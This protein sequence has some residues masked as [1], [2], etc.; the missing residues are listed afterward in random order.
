MNRTPFNPTAAAIAAGWIGLVSLPAAEVTITGADLLANPP[1]PTNTW[2]SA[3]GKLTFTA[4]NDLGKTSTGA[5]G[6]NNP[7][8]GVA[9]G[10]NNVAVDDNASGSEALELTFAADAG[11]SSIT[12]NFNTADGVTYISGFTSNPGVVFVPNPNTTTAIETGGATYDDSTGTVTINFNLNISANISEIKF[13]RPA[14][15]AGQTLTISRPD[16][17]ANRQTA[18]RSYTYETDIDTSLQIVGS[19]AFLPTTTVDNYE[20]PD[21]KLFIEGWADQTQTTAANFGVGGGYFFGI[22][23]GGNDNA[24]NG[25]ESVTI[26]VASDAALD[27]MSFAWPSAVGTVEIT[28]FASDPLATFDGNTV[29]GETGSVAYSAGTLTITLTR[30]NGQ[31]RLVSFGNPSASIG[32]LLT[33]QRTGGTG[34]FSLNYIGYLDSIPPS[35]PVI[36]GDLTD[37]LSVIADTPVDLGVILDP[38]TSPAPTYLWEYDDGLGGGF[39]P[40]PGDNTAPIYEFTGGTAT[41][42]NY[43]VTVTN[44]E[45]S[46]TST[47]TV[48]STDDGDG[49]NNQWEIDNFGD[50]LLYEDDDVEPDGLTNSVEF[51]LGTDPN[52]VDT[53]GDGLN[54]ADEGPNNADPLVLDTD[55]D[56]Y[57]DG[58]EVNVAVPATLPDDPNSS[59]GVSDGRNSIGITFNTIN[60]PGANRTLG[61]NAL[62]GAPGYVQKNWNSTGALLGSAT[63]TNTFDI[64]TPSTGT[65]VDSSGNSTFTGFDIGMAGTFSV[66]NNPQQPYGSLYSAYLFANGTTTKVTMDITDIP[67]AR[68]DVVI[69]PLG[70]NGNQRGELNQFGETK[71]YAARPPA[72]VANGVDPVWYLSSDQTTSSNGTFENFPRA[73]HLV[74]RGLTDPDVGFDLTRTLD[75]IGIAAIQIVEDLDSDG[76][77]M[78]DNYE[79]SVGLDPND[80]GTTDPVK[81]GAN[82]DF[83]G[84][85]LL[86]IDEHDNGTNPTSNDT[87]NDG[88]T[89]DVET[90]TGTWVSI[91]DTGTDP[92]IADFDNDGVPDGA[93]TNTGIFVNASDTGGNPLVANVDTDQD[94]W[95]DSYEN[96]AGATDFLN[97]E[98][99]GG[100]N[101]DGFAIAFDAANGTSA[102]AASTVFLP[103]TYAGAPGVEM[104]NWNRSGA[105]GFGANTGSITDFGGSLS[106]SA[107]AVVGDGVTGVD[108]DFTAGGGA[109]SSNPELNSPYGRLF[110]SFIFGRN[111]AGAGESPDSTVTLTGIPYTTYDVYV[112]V[113]S[114]S[115]G[116]IGTISSTAAGTTYSFTTGVVNTDPGTYTQTTD[117]GA[118]NPIANYA[119]FSAQSG[120]TFDVTVTVGAAQNSLG[121]YGIQVVDTTGSQSPFEAWAEANI[122]DPGQRLPTDDPDGDGTEN[123]GEYAF[124]TDP[125]DAGS[126][127]ELTTA[128]AGGDLTLTYN[129]AKDAS[130]ITYTPEWSTDLVNWFTTDV[131]DVPTGTEDD[132]IIEYVATIAQ[133]MDDTKF[134]RIQVTQP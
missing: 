71:T 70:F 89:D 120:G 131:T 109:Y 107:G 3:D 85:G 116:R 124:F 101:P 58:Y 24:V 20:T 9:G 40:A 123:L 96:G 64:A 45:G 81:E 91:S 122:P 113:G 93:E 66:V 31:Q 25:N 48:T 11:L 2:T 115:G 15:S 19:E 37:P 10:A 42:G 44:S 126:F 134:L 95:S 110:N 23:G 73:T 86:N 27:F 54:D 38:N 59:P 128:V 46:D 21:A 32:Q 133:G 114:E 49:I 103:N 132:D 79:I 74:F 26:D 63:S 4:W 55:G 102:G 78:G 56:G 127:P 88:Y 68:Y 43:R 17:G 16:S 83:D 8:I 29:D 119:V 94:G 130:G 60:G 125:D 22:Q 129:R 12:A 14:A 108:V 100:P 112:Y 65:L 98:D 117:T 104:K 18:I 106:D 5:L 80:D 105:L 13:L 92:R 47:T 7:F 121:I 62:A 111:P 36:V 76:D 67:Y 118:G 41:D 84:D 69:Y 87:D 77:G 6:Y 57:S 1:S 28:G 35:P 52:L 50:H 30:F 34:Q 99:P 90:D 51:A 97:P 39:V 53:D 72:L 82:G 33:V 75:N 61:P